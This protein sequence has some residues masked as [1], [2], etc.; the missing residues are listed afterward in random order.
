MRRQPQRLEC[1]GFAA[2]ITASKDFITKFD[3]PF[4]ICPKMCFYTNCKTNLFKLL[5]IFVALECL[6]FAG[7][8]TAS[9]KGL[10]QPF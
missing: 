5:H 6:V 2:T 9:K 7:T 8:I 1:L 4:H 3:L 10:D